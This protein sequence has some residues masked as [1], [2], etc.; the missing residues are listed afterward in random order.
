MSTEQTAQIHARSFLLPIEPRISLHA[1][2]KTLLEAARNDPNIAKKFET[3]KQKLG[4]GKPLIGKEHSALFESMKSRQVV[5]NIPTAPEWLRP[6]IAVGYLRAK[7][8]V[9]SG[10]AGK[11]LTDP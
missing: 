8:A 5:P 9:A 10:K 11:L 4:D 6:L 2:G 3:I 1:I 7:E